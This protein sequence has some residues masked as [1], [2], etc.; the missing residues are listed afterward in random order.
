[1]SLSS[2]AWGEA[3]TFASLVLRVWKS[4]T[5]VSPM[6]PPVLAIASMSRSEALRGLSISAREFVCEQMIGTPL[7]IW[8]A[9]NDVRSPVWPHTSSTMRWL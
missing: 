6:T 2:V 3:L 7:E 5:D 8:I 1:M 9:S 4:L